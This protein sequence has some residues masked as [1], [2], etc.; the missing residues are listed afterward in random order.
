MNFGGFSNILDYFRDILALWNFEDIQHLPIKV[1][2]SY[3]LDLGV[4]SQDRH[5]WRDTPDDVFGS[6]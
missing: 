2:I 4:S 3:F 5:A 1:S 6:L